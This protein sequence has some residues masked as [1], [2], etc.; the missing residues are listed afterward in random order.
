MEF[1]KLMMLLAILLALTGIG[2]ELS[3]VLHRIATALEHA[4]RLSESTRSQASQR[5]DTPTASGSSAGH[6][7]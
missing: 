3:N 7:E 4:N 6:A 1:A 2:T 5:A